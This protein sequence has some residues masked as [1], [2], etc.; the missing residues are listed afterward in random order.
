MTSNTNSRLSQ[1]N[2]PGANAYPY[3][4]FTQYRDGSWKRKIVYPGRES[5]SHGDMNG[6]FWESDPNG[7]KKDHTIA[8]RWEYTQHG[9]TQTVEAN[10]DSKIGGSDTK[11]VSQDE[12]SEHGNDLM[13]AIAGSVIHAAGGTTFIHSTKGTQI[14]ST[15]DHVTDHNDGSHHINI[16]NDHVTFVGNNRYDFVQNEFGVFVSNGNMDFN[17]NK[18]ANI[19]SNEDFTIKSNTS[20]TI[21]VGNSAIVV[22]SM[23]IT[24]QAHGNIYVQS[25]TGNVCLGGNSS[26]SVSWIPVLLEGGGPA[27]NVVGHS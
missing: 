22:N 13:K 9:K 10:H 8:D 20:V 15:G 18:K 7:S 5:T 24:I 27:A 26:S 19:Q 25:L 14:A 17:V 1:L 16:A 23:G 11:Y 2:P 6:S 3:I 4:E 21:Q 12:Y